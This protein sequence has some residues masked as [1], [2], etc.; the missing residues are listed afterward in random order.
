MVKGL[1]P[2]NPSSTVHHNHHQFKVHYSSMLAGMGWTVYA[3]GVTGGYAI[4]HFRKFFPLFLQICKKN[5]LFQI[6]ARV[7]NTLSAF[8]RN[9]G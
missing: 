1:H 5:W 4:P 8:C 6:S 9:D 2:A 7:L 3:G